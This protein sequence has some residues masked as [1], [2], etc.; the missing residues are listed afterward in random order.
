MSLLC[1]RGD[2]SNNNKT[3]S[4]KRI[5][6]LTPQSILK[7]T[8]SSSKFWLDGNVPH[9]LSTFRSHKNKNAP[10]NYSNFHIYYY[11][12]IFI[13]RTGG[14]ILNRTVSPVSVGLQC[15]WVRC[16]GCCLLHGNSV[17]ASVQ[18][19]TI[20]PYHKKT[21]HRPTY[22]HAVTPRPYMTE[23]VRHL[24]VETDIDVSVRYS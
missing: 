21:Q 20:G 7:W 3:C 12:K 6:P 13:D 4:V 1:L 16:R 14:Q 9:L 10:V 15:E 17:T 5:I 24:R 8:P 2:N 22:T 11:I 23:S 18:R 19:H